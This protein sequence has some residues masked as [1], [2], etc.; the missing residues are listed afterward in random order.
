MA[1]P[2]SVASIS[3]TASS[4]PITSNS[5]T[6]TAGSDRVVA[7]NVV[8]FATGTPT[9]TATDPAG[10]AMT[11]VQP[12][13]GVGGNFWACSFRAVAPGS[14]TGPVTVSISMDGGGSFLGGGVFGEYCTS[15]TTFNAPSTATG[16]TNAPT[17]AVTGVTTNDRV[18]D[19]FIGPNET[20]S[21]GADQTAIAADTVVATILKVGGSWQL[22]SADLTGTMSRSWSGPGDTWGIIAGIITGTASDANATLVGG[23]LINENILFGRLVQ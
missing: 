10:N 1:A 14:A 21:L 13:T 6:T 17:V 8:L 16:S 23:D 11:V 9:V 19:A 18:I 20:Y 2:V 15:A 22:G 7:V 4:A 5:F 12:V 3:G